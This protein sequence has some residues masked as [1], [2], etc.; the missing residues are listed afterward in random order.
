MFRKTARPSAE[1]NGQA[2]VADAGPCQKSLKLRV[3]RETISPIRA[4]VLAEFQRKA[5]LP[6]FRKGKAPIELVERQHGQAIQ[7]ETL[8]RAM[9]GAFEQAAKAH[10]LKPVGPFEVSK[11]DFTEQEGLTLEATVEVEPAF[12]L[13]AYKGMA[14]KEP[15][16]TV[17]PEDL[18]KG[19]QQLQESMAQL[20][21]GQEGEEKQRQLPA[22]DDEL[23]KDL[24]FP[25]LP[26]LKEH[27]GA[28]LREQRRAAQSQ[29]LEAALCDE[30]IKR[31]TFDVPPRLVQHQTERLGQDF[32]TRLMLSGMAE[33]QV[34]QE[35]AKFSDQLRTNAERYV[36]LRFILDRIAEQESVTV[37]QD[38]LVGRLWQL[39]Q[40]WKKDP[41]EVRKIFDAQG[42]WPS[43]VS[44]LR[45]E[46]TI[47][48][49]FSVAAIERAAPPAAPEV[50]PPAKSA[51]AQPSAK[52]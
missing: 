33:A 13:A 22:I 9:R 7:D 15:A 39:S 28:K 42:L 38:E 12:K 4:A 19:L 27:L 43:V 32:K 20:V 5:A 25:D 16:A 18:E 21:P 49:L 50:G 3:A 47:A 14:L 46:K 17:A 1:P 6:G 31:H 34:T 52:P 40:R 35:L 8:Q 48:W 44:T 45:Q 41:I 11:A 26:K 37:T 23:A 29:T 36:K 2:T 24:G 30:L 10:A 51:P